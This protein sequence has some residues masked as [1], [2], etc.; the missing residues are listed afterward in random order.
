M[1]RRHIFQ[2]LVLA[3]CQALRLDAAEALSQAALPPQPFGSLP[4][5]RQLRWHEMEFYGFVHFTVNTFTDKEWGYGDESETG[6][7]PTDFDADQIAPTA[8]DAAMKAL[9]PTPNPPTP[10]SFS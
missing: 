9:I 3:L 2:M 5:P 8:K 4:T 10:F 1:Y 6:F 7:N